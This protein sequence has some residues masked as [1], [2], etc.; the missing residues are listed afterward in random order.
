MAIR[1]YVIGS[2]EMNRVEDE[3]QAKLAIGYQ[4]SAISWKLYELRFI[5]CKLKF[6]II[7]LFSK[8]FAF[9][10]PQSEIRNYF[11]MLHAQCQLSLFCLSISAISF[12]PSAISWKLYEL[13]F[14]CCKLKSAIRYSK[15]EIISLCSM[16]H[17]LCVFH[18]FS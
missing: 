14:I 5:C 18:V 11:S 3:F 1:S 4:P 8:F 13:C 17:A 16:L 15:F 10:N 7:S 2:G 6:A 12:Q 9:S